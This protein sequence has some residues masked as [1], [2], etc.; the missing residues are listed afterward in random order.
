MLSTRFHAKFAEA[1][2]QGIASEMD[3]KIQPA[4][5]TVVI[6]ILSEMMNANVHLLKCVMLAFLMKV[7]GLIENEIP[8]QIMSS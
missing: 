8:M 7:I 3:A 4:A 6:F 5:A 1:I 2:T